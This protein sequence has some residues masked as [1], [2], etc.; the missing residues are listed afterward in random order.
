MKKLLKSLLSITIVLAILSSL[1]SC[2]VS[3]I[4][5][6]QIGDLG[7]VIRFGNYDE[8]YTGGFQMSD[9]QLLATEI[10]WVE[11]YEE[12]R[13]IIDILIE[14]GS[15]IESTVLPTYENEIVDAKYCFRF[16]DAKPPKRGQEWYDRQLEHVFVTYYGFLDTLSIEELEHSYHLFYRSIEFFGS[17][18]GDELPDYNTMIYELDAKK[19][20][21]YYRLSDTETYLGSLN[22]YK[23]TEDDNFFTEE[24]HE[25]FIGSIK[26]VYGNKSE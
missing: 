8:S 1:T 9:A 13:K 14:N 3:K 5:L 16:N 11:T 4:K 20:R 19:G 18:C 25:E 10:F 22:Y 6:Y 17:W 12:A 15:E 7:P 21:Y 26:W 2:N 23:I 24:F